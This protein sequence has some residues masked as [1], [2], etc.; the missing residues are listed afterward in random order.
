MSYEYKFLIALT[1]TLLVEVPIVFAVIRLAFKDKKPAT[2][3]L[4]ATTLFASTLTLPYLWFIFRSFQ[5]NLVYSEIII[6][7]IE[8]IIYFAILKI[9]FKKAL[10]LSIVANLASYAFGILF[11]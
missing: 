3:Q 4:L 7:L 10:T 9:P 5:L 2:L 1:V 8:A 6:V 11:F